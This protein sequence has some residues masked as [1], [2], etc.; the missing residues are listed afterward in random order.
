MADRAQSTALV[1][2][3]TF[4]AADEGPEAYYGGPQHSIPIDVLVRFM[5][6]RPCLNTTT[7]CIVYIIIISTEF[8]CSNV[9]QNLI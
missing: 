6:F 7:I 8:N 3:E 4:Y 2:G 9:I 5:L 1:D